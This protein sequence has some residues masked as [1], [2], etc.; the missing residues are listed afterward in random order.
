MS[1]LLWVL[2]AFVF[3]ALFVTLALTTLR[4]GHSVLFWVGNIFP[5]PWIIAALM[6]PTAGT[7]APG[8]PNP[9]MSD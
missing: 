9:P 1:T 5:M 4:D 6:G 8:S 7:G 3:V 2:P